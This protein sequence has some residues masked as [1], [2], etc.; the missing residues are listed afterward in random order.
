MC[1]KFNEKRTTE[2]RGAEGGGSRGNCTPYIYKKRVK[3][4]FGEEVLD[5]SI[6]LWK[7]CSGQ[8]GVLEPK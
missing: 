2:T 3:K 4:R 5:P 6:V 1:G 8:W 7:F